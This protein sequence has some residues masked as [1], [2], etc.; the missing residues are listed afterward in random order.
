MIAANLRTAA[1]ATA[2][3]SL[4]GPI[5]SRACTTFVLQD[6][7]R[8]YF[9][10]NLDWDWENGLL[11]V[12][13]R[14]VSKTAFLESGGTPAKW[15]SRFGSVTFNQLGQDQP[16]GGMNEAG[17]VIEDMM[18]F[19]TR[20]PAPDGRP[21]INMLQWIQYQLD[22]CR[23]V[24]D[25]IRTDGAIRMEQPKV[26]AR[27]HYLVCDASGDC[28]TIEFLDGKM[29]CHRGSTLPF[30]ALANDPYEPSAAFARAHP[31]PTGAAQKLNDPSSLLR[32]TCA[33]SRSAQFK[34]V[35]PA[36]D[37]DYAFA[38][39]EMVRQGPA[40]VWQVVYDLSSRRIHFQT[41]SHPRRR[42]VEMKALDFACGQA[43][44]CLDLQ[45]NPSDQAALVF[46]DGSEK[47]QRE[48]LEKFTAQDSVKQGLGDLTP[49]LESYFQELRAYTCGSK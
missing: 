41:R 39:L 23:T 4:V 33:A 28:A 29:V 25:V 27:I 34:S 3:L 46:E 6:G 5:P 49:L 15:I 12:N 21:E 31:I 37:V 18:L 8:V 17:L 42:I 44:K 38:T 48:Y 10:R 7:G 24:A 16:F 11:F 30:R 36:A 26:P 14:G 43:V 9:G 19:E 22:N 45:A 20:Y 32:F 35:S 1:L 2:F 13:Q 40:T 47:R